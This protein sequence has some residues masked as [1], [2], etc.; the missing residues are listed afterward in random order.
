VPEPAILQ[1][2]NEPLRIFRELES[3]G[4]LTAIACTDEIP[5]FAQ[6]DPEHCYISWQ[7]TLVGDTSESAIREAFE[8]IIDDCQLEIKAVPLGQPKSVEAAT[9]QS[10]EHPKPT[11]VTAEK[12]PA[13]SGKKTIAV[14][15][16]KEIPTTPRN[17]KT[18]S[19]RVDID[20]VD[21]LINLVGELVITQS[22][23]S[24][25]GNNFDAS[26]VDRLQSGLE[27]LLQNTKELQES[28]MR[29]R[30]LPISNAFNR[31]PR[32]VRDMALKLGKNID[33]KITGEQT[34][35]DKT[36]MEQIS[37]PLVHLVRNSLD[38]G[39]E[40]PQERLDN[41]KSATGTVF[42]NAFHQGGNIIIEV[43][44]DGAGLNIK[45]IQEKAIEKGIIAANEQLTESQV[46]DLLFE[47]GFS[48]AEAV[49]DISGRGVGMDVV[50]RNINSL[51]GSIEV[52]SE[53]GKGSTFRIR[54]PL[55]LAILDGQLVKVGAETYIIPLISIIESLQ[56]DEKQIKYVSGNIELYRLRNENIPII[57]TYD[58]FSIKD[59]NQNLKN[60][61]LVVVEGEGHKAALL[62]DDLL[63]Q[64]Q[65]V[66]KS[67][68][69]N[70]KRV[71]G[72]SGATILGDGTV[73]LIVDVAG[74]I[75]SNARKTQHERIHAA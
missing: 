29:V 54:L 38:H 65:F 69:T 5:I 70:Y 32:V 26:K 19:I 53:Q 10:E 17:V 24:E 74:F 15:P 33:L 68:E 57:R 52:E 11:E 46:H 64:Q 42:L 36:V 48:T 66:I 61:L 58:E 37:D 73:A 71:A 45:R 4:K 34:E 23:L 62:V 2:G 59:A 40:M 39:I 49:T 75:K 12:L 43:G 21:S 60:S 55:T 22:M 28:V 13:T 8:W 14:N 3:L 63:A 31:F 50:R 16:E 1:T 44:D 20:K 47:A 30:M 41:N 6:L 56:V 18:T 7:L 9:K 51:G 25:L 27:Q 72:I 35:L 67:L